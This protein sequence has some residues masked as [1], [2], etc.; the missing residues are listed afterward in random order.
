MKRLLTLFVFVI[1]TILSYGQDVTIGTGT[2][3]QNYPLSNYYG[4]ERS[5]ALYTAAEVNQTGFI[6]KIAWD[7]G[8]KGDPRPLKIYLK[9]VTSATLTANNWSSFIQGATLVYDE[10]FN[11]SVTGFNTFQFN[12]SFKYTGGTNNLLVL[13]ETNF[14]GFGLDG[15]DGLSIKATSETNMHFM[16]RS[17]SAP[18][19]GNLAAQ[20]SRPNVKLSFG[21]QITCLMPEGITVTST[22]QTSVSISWSAKAGVPSYDVYISTS[23]T[24]PAANA[25]V[26]N[27]N[28]TSY[29][30]PNLTNTTVYYVWV[31]S[32]CSDT[33]QSFW[34]SSIKTRTLCGIVNLP[35]WEGFNTDSA[36]LSC[37]T[38]KDENGDS[39]SATSNGIWK[40]STT[41]FEG[42]QSM[43]FY[44]STTTKLPHNDW[45]ISPVFKYNPNK[46]YRLK[47]HYRTNST[48]S[49]DY[50]F[51]V[52]LSDGG[53]ALSNFTK[54]IVPKKKYAA[55]NDWIE[56]VYYFNGVTADFQLAWQVT[57]T[58]STT[59]LY[60]DN[61]FVEEVVG[62]PEPLKL[63]ASNITDFSA[64]IGWSDDF[65]T[66]WQYYVQEEGIGLPDATNATT[67]TQKNANV[68]QDSS[69]NTLMDN[70]V[71]EFYVR[72]SCG[73]GEYSEWAG[74]FKFKTKCGVITVLPFEEGFNTNSTTFAC[75][76]IV[77][78]K[79]NSI[80]ATNRWR[81]S[82]STVYEGDRTMYYYATG[83]PNDDW[84]ITPTFTL[85]GG[86]YEVSYYYRTTGSANTEYE[87]LLSTTGTDISSFT[88]VIMP[89]KK[90]Q[91]GA[92]TKAV[93]YV[94]GTTGN[95]NI[96]IRIVNSGYAEM[97]LDKFR[98]ESVG[99]IAPDQ[100]VSVTNATA[101]TATLT[102]IDT[103]NANWDYAVVSANS[104]AP[105]AGTSTTNKSVTVTQTTGVG[106]A[107]LQPNTE[108]DF[109]VRS[110][111]VGEGGKS[112]WIGPIRFRTLCTAFT[113]PYW[114][115]FNTDSSTFSCWT[116]I[117][118][119]NPT[120]WDNI[121]SKDAFTKQE[122]THSLSYSGYLYPIRDHNAWLIS[123]TFTVS[124]NKYYVLKYYYRADTYASVDFDLLSSTTGS[125]IP[126]FTNKLITKKK[127]NSGKWIEQR[128]TVS[129]AT[130]GTMAFAWH[131]NTSGASSTSFYI[132]AVSFEE[133][134]CPEP[135]A[136]GVSNLTS[137]SATLGWTDNFG[138]SWEYFVQTTGKTAPAA[139]T[140]GVASTT[141]SVN[142]TAVTGGGAL[143][144][145]TEYEYYVRTM[146][147]DEKGNSIWIGPFVFRTNCGVYSLPFWEGFNADSET[148]RCWEIIDGNKDSTSPTSS[149]IW[150]PYAYT[151]YEGSGSMY[152]YGY[153]T[154]QTKLPHNDWLISPKM[155]FVPGKTYRLKYHYR[156]STTTS[157]DYEFE[158]L[159]SDTNTLPASFNKT[160]V[161]KKKYPASSNWV[162]EY[163]FFTGPTADFNIA[164]HVTSPTTGT[165]LYID[166]VFIEEVEGCPEPLPSSLG[167]KDPGKKD[168]TL[169]WEDKFGATKWEYYIQNAGGNKP[170]KTDK[171]IAA[172]TKQVVAT[173][174]GKGDN[175]KGNTDYEYYVRTDCGNGQYSIWSGPFKFTTLCDYYE[176]PFWEGF[177]SN[178]VQYR[179]WSTMDKAG[180][181]KGITSPWTFSTSSYEGDRAVYFSRYDVNK[182]PFNDWLISPD[183]D[184]DG[185]MYIL[186]YHYKTNT[187]ATHNPEFEVV[188]SNNGI[189]AS[190][191]KK[192]LIPS[193]IKREANYVEEVVFFSGVTGK[194]NIA[195][196]VNAKDTQY[197]YL[198]LDNV[199]LKK[200]TT[201]PEPYAVKTSNPTSTTIDVSWSQMPG[202]TSWEV[203][204][205]PYGSPATATPIKT[206]QVTGTPSTT[207]S[208]LDLSTAYA[209]YV[210]AKCNADSKSDP[211]T[212]AN[213]IT[214]M[215][216]NRDCGTAL[217]IPVT[218]NS[219]CSA[220]VKG[221]LFGALPSSI[222][223]PTCNTSIV[224][225]AWFEF[226]AQSAQHF[227]N[228][229]ELFSLSNQTLS[230]NVALYNQPCNTLVGG[231]ARECFVLSATTPGRMLTNLV[232]GQKY[233]IRIGVSG[234]SNSDL[235]FELCLS[236]PKYLDTADQPYTVEQLIKDVL[237]VSDCD[238]VSNVTSRTG[239]NFGE[240]NGIGYFT[241][242]S[243]LFPFKEGIVLATNGRQ[244]VPGPQTGAH[245]SN[246]YNWLGDTDLDRLLIKNGQTA[247]TNNA[248]VLEFDF[249]PIVE[250]IAFNFLF[251]SEEYGTFQCSFADVFAFFLTDLTTGEVTNLAVIPNTNIPVAVTTIRDKKYNTGCE[252]ANI[253]YFGKYFGTNGLLPILDPINY[254]GM[255]T[256]L[257]AQSKV[258]PGRKYHIKLAIA[259]YSDTAYQS[260]V[261]LEAGSFNLGSLDMGAD[262]T[263]DNGTALC[264]GELR[265][266]NSGL[267]GDPEVVSITWYKDGKLI[268]GE[269]NP[270]LFINETGTYKVIGHYNDINC[271]IAGEV[272]AEI[273]PPIHTVVNEAL[274]IDLCRFA[275]ED[276]TI[277]LTNST[278]DVFSKVDD[279]NYSLEFFY[280]ENAKELI[281]IPEEYILEN[282]RIDHKIYYKIVDLRTG[283]TEVFNFNIKFNEGSIPKKPIDVLVCE[284]YALLNT[285]DN[286][287]YYTEPGGKGT[288]YKG[289]DILGPGI[290][291]LFLFQD[292]GDFCYEEVAFK[293]EVTD[294]IDLMVIEDQTLECEIYELP[295]LPIN[296]KYF[297]EVE[298][299]RFELLPGT[300]IPQTNTKV[301]IVAESLNKI[302]Y[303]ETSFVVRYNDC[304]IPKGFSPNGDGIN[305]RFDLSNHGVT[306]IKVYNR[307]GTE[308]YSH[309]LGYTNQWD[310]KD[311]K[312]KELS[313][314]TYYYVIQAFEKTRTGWVQINK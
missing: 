110:S 228:I 116:L 50:E 102:W 108:Y 143:Q 35:F 22:T 174:D 83:S 124:A 48:A 149:G 207:I 55:S 33:D 127:E 288:K 156:T 220:T 2:V 59:Y 298:G 134:Q 192:V 219:L 97:Y 173:K 274:K 191:F 17:D 273:F 132:D 21:A 76:T 291:N 188:L 166:N 153:T 195:W 187:T 77:D 69:G 217:T 67:T 285:E 236:T 309:G 70:T 302:C 260:A 31:R 212:V 42:N 30:F 280:D 12:E 245:G 196:H 267:V 269:H 243:N 262:L 252:S 133:V 106:G 201:C 278:K 170:A 71:Y 4:Y 214:Q 51:Q 180:V 15:F 89:K 194:S 216:N 185:G 130:N 168:I 179:C 90:V 296:N 154:D 171:G 290:H 123:P 164:W 175:L 54:V 169:F 289:G 155:K 204:V 305:D 66:S 82:S 58:T 313:S 126:N 152:F 16:V 215:G 99:C 38:I 23:S 125:S 249:V 81:Q 312:G 233:Y 25:T 279:S 200:V 167:A 224:K 26:V 310:G 308:V 221:S 229:S 286:Q 177:N 56:A 240:G 265:E 161:S 272:F 250:N 98:I 73:N 199:I 63:E 84:L 64:T 68:N 255:T 18:P 52:L 13:V 117:N 137:N 226:T 189:V 253:D 238:L 203:I 60:I 19:T 107:A 163:V 24:Q 210:F 141:K 237:V 292:N 144:P 94:T 118:G 222:P 45:L 160:I 197:S 283:C 87:V 287:M 142:V 7:I 6:N 198:Y 103:Y 303:D 223:A 34:S 92:Y 209:V 248:S 145:N 299:T 40:T 131:I 3:N 100:S 275:T 193:T 112:K 140:S 80:S 5:A 57:S 184:L 242:E 182:T 254:R 176:A 293:V 297:I 20:T 165:Y 247:G 78:N 257:I 147:G 8:L 119:E 261:F 234:T 36:G 241:N 304:P 256:P 111:C 28:S 264:N 186:K 39:T 232:I 151:Y 61:V 43:Y 251:A 150:Q 263:V 172:T 239:S 41:S 231:T 14:G 120:T 208:G 104:P 62:C 301:Y 138:T 47:Y 158:V 91:I 266:I 258:Q 10:V 128:I 129:S 284:S 11:P 306:S 85:N 294:R 72:A 96:A 314:G 49:Y 65:G 113:A 122:G 114:E 259:N 146:C 211:S 32:H 1:C 268:E 311:K 136:L 79:P 183:I 281:E 37:W 307:N 295:E 44:G 205:V 148:T 178:E 181:I 277:D 244:Y 246:S 93:H 88:K 29:T 9:E 27:V 218:D 271:E 105:T 53:G 206:V 235:L 282:G 162:E 135:Y 230:V 109:Y 190:E 276:L 121:W 115:G 159:L 95:V 139:T 202:I 213:F 86:N 74:P 75:W 46:I 270:S 101:T 157:Y 227:L 225:D 300:L